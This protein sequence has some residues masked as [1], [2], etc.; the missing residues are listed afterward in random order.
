MP[1]RLLIDVAVIIHSAFALFAVFGA[2]IAI[3]WKRIIWF[4]VPAVLWAALIE[5]GNWI[6][7]ITPLEDWLREKTISGIGY[8]E[9]YIMPILYPDNLTRPVQFVLGTGVLVINIFAYWKLVFR[10]ERAGLGP[11]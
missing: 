5:L 6:C 2:L 4:H 9:P 3:K 1:I 11:K 7:P 10:K 8:I